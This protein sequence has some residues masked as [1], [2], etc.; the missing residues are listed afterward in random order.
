MKRLPPSNQPIDVVPNTKR[1][2]D[3]PESLA[4]LPMARHHTSVDLLMPIAHKFRQFR[5]GACP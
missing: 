3:T 4:W 1:E 5:S 2:R